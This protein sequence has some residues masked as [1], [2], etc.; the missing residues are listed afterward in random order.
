MSQVELLKLVV[1]IL[2]SLSIDYM[3]VGSHASS[4]YGEAR[5]T[6]DIDMVIDLNPETIPLLIAQF[7]SQ[8]YYL[9]E[10]ALREGRMANLIDLETGDKVDLFLLT[11][12]PLAREQFARRRS[13]NILGIDLMVASV[14]DTIISK[15][16]WSAES[17]GSQQQ[18][19]DV[20]EMI[21]L[22]KQQL[23]IAYIRRQLAQLGL[24]QAWQEIAPRLEHE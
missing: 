7:D 20:R 24:T 22:R 2:G 4:F 18:L 11:S 9:S 1:E 8:R 17:G 5:S 14:E 13:S 23:D 15:L 16:K 10:I 3:L 12:E 6:H 21:R 19:S